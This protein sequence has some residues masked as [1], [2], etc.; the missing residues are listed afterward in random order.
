MHQKALIIAILLFTSVSHSKPFYKSHT[1]EQK[2]GKFSFNILFDETVENTK[3]K[4]RYFS[5]IIQLSI[6]NSIV[7]RKAVVSP[8]NT[9]KI[10]KVSIYQYDKNTM[11]VRIVFEEGFDALQVKDKFDFSKNSKRLSLNLENFTNLKPS[12]QLSKRLDEI[13]K[14][15]EEKVSAAVK[16][17]AIKPTASFAVEKVAAKTAQ[18]Q[19]SVNNNINRRPSNLNRQPLRLLY[20]AL[21][22]IF[23]ALAM[24][25]FGS[26]TRKKKIFNSNSFVHVSDEYSLGL[27]QKLLVVEIEGTQYLFIKNIFKTRFVSKLESPQHVSEYLQKAV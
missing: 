22:L 6:P 13:E 25:L 11:R 14:E 5:N 1:H 16:P 10:D 15:V 26:V 8:E 27:F 19:V 2:N 17:P 4:T 7:M 9:Q 3:I 18:S 12:F 23:G 21:G 20:A 24:V